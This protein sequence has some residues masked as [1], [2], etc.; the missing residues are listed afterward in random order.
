MNSDGNRYLEK[1]RAEA[2]I[3]HLL[4]SRN[5]NVQR[6]TELERLTKRILKLKLGG[7]QLEVRR[8]MAQ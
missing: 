6:L 5:R 8:W 7:F 1:L 3:E 2:Q 4:R